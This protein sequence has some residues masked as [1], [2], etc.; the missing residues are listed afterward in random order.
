MKRSLLV[1]LL[2][3]SLFSISLFAFSGSMGVV[4]KAIS[5][6]ETNSEA[7]VLLLQDHYKENPESL[8]Q[9][10]MYLENKQAYHL[11]REFLRSIETSPTSSYELFRLDLI[12]GKSEFLFGDL[13]NAARFDVLDEN[14]IEEYY[15]EIFSEDALLGLL[16]FLSNDAVFSLLKEAVFESEN[17]S[18][19]DEIILTNLPAASANEVSDYLSDSWGDEPRD[20]SGIIESYGFTNQTARAMLFY[21]DYLSENYE[22]VLENAGSLSESTLKELEIDLGYL[23]MKSAFSIQD[24]DAAKE[25][26]N[27][28]AFPWDYD[29]S[30]WNYLI[31][32]GLN[33]LDF[34]EKSLLGVK[35]EEEYAY[36]SALLS[37]INQETNCQNDFED[38]IYE[39]EGEHL[40]LPQ[41][42]LAVSVFYRGITAMDE[43]A[44]LLQRD[45]LSAESEAVSGNDFSYAYLGTDAESGSEVINAY[46]SYLSCRE[47]VENG[48]K[49]AAKTKLFEI[50]ADSETP[51]V[52]E[53]LA[54]KL[55]LKLTS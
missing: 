46:L 41:A 45:L 50:L 55:L 43:T 2:L 24:Y 21:S 38:Y 39:I 49:E 53:S 18:G 1:T 15:E 51:E 26:M 19:F 23:Q 27:V 33:D 4:T 28:L 3:I 8:S 30:K 54:K 7:A 40:Y 12:A 32:L 31:A 5:V 47:M 13:T 9:L 36:F 10:T 52:V 48:E 37:M 42:L 20:L 35:S 29:L 11:C 6:S 22:A 16:P 25:F 14:F 44:V 34:A 17:Y